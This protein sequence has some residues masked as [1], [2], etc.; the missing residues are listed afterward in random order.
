MRFISMVIG[1]L[2]AV[3]FIVHLIKGKK[4]MPMVEKLDDSSYPLHDLY[5]VGFSLSKTKLFAFRG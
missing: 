3:L 1:T 4:Y 5:V 2:L